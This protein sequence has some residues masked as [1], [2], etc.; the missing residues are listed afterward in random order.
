MNFGDPGNFGKW[1][2][3]KQYTFVRMYDESH[4]SRK[5]TGGNNNSGCLSVIVLVVAVSA[6]IIKMLLH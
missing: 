1:S 6:F 5:R 4:K 3:Q 2:P